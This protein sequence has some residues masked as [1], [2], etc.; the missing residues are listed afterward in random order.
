MNNS[1]KAKVKSSGIIIEVY[2]S[3][4]RNKWINAT[5]C[6]TEYDENELEFI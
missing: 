6:T 1:K 2:K 3:S 4:L 5:D